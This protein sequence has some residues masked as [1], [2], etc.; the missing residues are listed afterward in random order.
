M[1]QKGSSMNQKNADD[2]PEQPTPEAQTT[3]QTPVPPEFSTST[4]K[5]EKTQPGRWQKFFR[6]LLT[7]LVVL[8]I[9]FL[10][11]ILTDHYLRYKPVQVELN[12]A[13]AHVKLL[14]VLVDVTNARLA[15]ALNDVEGAKAALINTQPRLDD[16]LPLIANFNASLAQSMPQRL[17]LIVSGLERDTETAKIDLELFTKD[18]LAIKA[19]LFID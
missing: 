1:T 16:L 6:R 9:V 19:A 8:A 3:S 15:L 13:T 11:G 5:A 18:L 10:A 17:S 7:W 14:Q 4:K 2:Q 12:T